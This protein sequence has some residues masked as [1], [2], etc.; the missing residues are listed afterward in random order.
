MKKTKLC[1]ICKKEMPKGMKNVCSPWCSRKHNANLKKAKELKLK[2]RK[3]KK[4]EKKAMSISKLVKQA[5]TLFSIY[6]RKKYSYDWENV[7]C[8]T[9]N[10][11]API[12]EM[13][14]WHFVSRRFY[15]T[16]WLETNCHPQNYKCNVW[17]AWEQFKHWQFIDKKYWEW[18]ADRLM[19]MTKHV[20]KITRE[21]LLQ[22]IE[23]IKNKLKEL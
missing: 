3:Q 20:N 10:E 23:N 15:A 8:V 16:R 4:R 11:I 13:Q 5:D 14:N 18:T 2:E 22:T 6:I 21:E 12:K 9:C 1:I 17:M 7:M 19:E